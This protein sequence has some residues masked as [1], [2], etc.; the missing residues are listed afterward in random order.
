MSTEYSN[1]TTVSSF[2]S[3]TPVRA[4]VNSAHA[5]RVVHTRTRAR[6]HAFLARSLAGGAGADADGD[7]AG[8]VAL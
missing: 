5:R 2:K 1:V 3:R 4:K 7:G 8:G 6:T